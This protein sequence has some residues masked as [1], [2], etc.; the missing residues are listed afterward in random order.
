[1][2][3]AAELAHKFSVVTVLE[4]VCVLIE[5]IAVTLGL[6]GK[7]ASVRSVNISVLCL[8]DR[9][10]LLRELVNES[11]KAVDEDKAHAIVLGC[12][13]MIGVDK[14]LQEALREKGYDVPVISPVPVSIK[15]L[16]TLISLKLTQ[17]SKTYMK[18]PEKERNIWERLEN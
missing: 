15:Y 1:M 2:L 14:Q 8:G 3:Y 18:P 13:G 10:K 9:E 17:S 5:K 6:K 7:L 16:E 12:T 11:I 4:N